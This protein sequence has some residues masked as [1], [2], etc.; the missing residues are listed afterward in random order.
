MS[1][2]RMLFLQ[3]ALCLAVLL[4]SSRDLRAWGQRECSLFAILSASALSSLRISSIPVEASASALRAEAM[5]DSICSVLT[6][7]QQCKKKR[8]FLDVH[9]PSSSVAVR[10]SFC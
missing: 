8:K 3:T 4:L 1:Q 7:I 5:S 6:D 9:G 10:I 2:R